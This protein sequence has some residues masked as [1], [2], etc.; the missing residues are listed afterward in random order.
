[1]IIAKKIAFRLYLALRFADFK[2]FRT[3]RTGMLRFI[4]KQP[5]KGFVAD[6]TVILTG[7]D[8][9]QIG[10]NFSV[11]HGSYISAEGGITFGDN[12]AIGH[13]TSILSTEH[14]YADA[15]QPIKF[16]P[17]TYK[18]VKLEDNIWI[19]ANV[20]ILGGVHLLS[21]TIVAAGA[22][23]TKSFDSG[24]II[25]GGVPARIIKRY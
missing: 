4:L 25:I 17:V 8:K 7:L 2:L 19:G 3:L 24:N 15:S 11:H 12:I 22:V 23:V 10:D 13:G 16:Q 1:M 14:G 5:L 9:L 20:T 18:P 21:G 6:K